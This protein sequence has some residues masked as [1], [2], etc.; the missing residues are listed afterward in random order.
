MIGICFSQLGHDRPSPGGPSPARAARCGQ[1]RRAEAEVP[2]P[3][4]D[5]SICRIGGA[6]QGRCPDG[7]G[8][9]ASSPPSIHYE[10][11]I[12]FIDLTPEQ[13]KALADAL[14]TLQTFQAALNKDPSL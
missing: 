9:G 11:G 2:R 13:L 10:S 8:P 14:A 6:C 7:L 12:E 3:R 4:L 1:G 5:G